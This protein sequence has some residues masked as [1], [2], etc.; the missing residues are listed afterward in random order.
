MHSNIVLYF[1][2]KKDKFEFF[3]MNHALVLE[4][5]ESMEKDKLEEILQYVRK[6]QDN[7]DNEV[8]II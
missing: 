4:G 8:R 6:M 2:Y 3:P 1:Q 5:K 7:L